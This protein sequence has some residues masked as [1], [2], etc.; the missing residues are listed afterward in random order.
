MVNSVESS[1]EV[2]TSLLLST[3]MT[4]TSSSSLLRK[5][6][7]Q[8]S[9]FCVQHFFNGNMKQLSL[10]P[11]D[12]ILQMFVCILA[13]NSLSKISEFIVFIFLEKLCFMSCFYLLLLQKLEAL[14][15]VRAD[16]YFLAHS[17]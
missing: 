13:S 14:R 4:M 9:V 12:D 11:A 17:V 15:R 5:T 2:S 7:K 6:L 1:K 10:V 8:L 16:L 3:L